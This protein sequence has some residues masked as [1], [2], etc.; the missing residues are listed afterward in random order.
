M[1][2]IE[3]IESKR[4]FNKRT[5]AVSSVYDIP[6]YESSAEKQ[7]WVLETYGFTWRLDNGTVGL[8]RPQALSRVDAERIMSEYNNPK[9]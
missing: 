1:K 4:W 6:P 7:D 5:G 8:G 2:I 3:V 9:V